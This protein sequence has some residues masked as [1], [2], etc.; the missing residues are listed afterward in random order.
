MTLVVTLGVAEPFA[1]CA[2][3]HAVLFRAV[4]D[5]LE[6]RVRV[7]LVSVAGPPFPVGVAGVLPLADGAALALASASRP[8]RH[9]PRSGAGRGARTV[10]RPA[11]GVPPARGDRR[12]VRPLARRRRHLDRSRPHTVHRPRL[13]SALPV[14]L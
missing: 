7:D 10:H 6:E 4:P 2:E 11:P 8:R 5:E 14:R 13:R 12:S 9:P 3:P 1:D